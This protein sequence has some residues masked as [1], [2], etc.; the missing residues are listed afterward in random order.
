MVKVTKA[1]LEKIA[2]DAKKYGESLEINELVD[3]LRKLSDKYFNTGKSLVD[4]KSYDTLKDVLKK[5]DPKNVYLKEVGAPIKG[6]KQKVKLPFPMGS[7]DK[8]KPKDSELV[9]S[10]TDKFTGPYVISDKLDG[11]SAQIYKD[12]TGKVTMYSR[13]DGLIGQDISHLLNAVHISAEALK[14]IPK[15]TSIRG[16]LVISKAEFSEIKEK[17]NMENARNTVSGLVNSK[18]VDMDIALIT[19][20]V[21]YTILSPRHKYLDQYKL[22]K[23]WGFE[24]AQYITYKKLE[25]EKLSEYL[26]ERKEKSIYEIDGIVCFDNSKVHTH[27]EGNPDYGFAFK[28]DFD[29]QLVATKIID[30]E[31]NVSK[32]GKLKPVAIVEP[33]RLTGVTVTRVTAINAKYVS[34]NMLGK[35]AIVKITRS[36]DVIPKIIEVV[37][38]AKKAKFPDTPYKW[39]NTGVDI[40]LEDHIKQPSKVMTIKQIAFFFEKIGVQN[41]GEGIVTKLVDNGYDSIEKVLEVLVNEDEHDELYEIDGLGKKMIDKIYENIK[42][43]FEKMELHIFMHASGKFDLGL[44]SKKI[45]EII[46]HIP[47]IMQKKFTDDVLEEKLLEVD[48]IKNILAKNFVDNFDKFKTFY[49]A[50]NKIIDISHIAKNN[51]KDVKKEKEN[52][53]VM[54]GETVVFTGFRDKDIEAFINDNGGKVTGSVSKNT[55]ILVHADNAD[56]TSAKFTKA[57]ELNIKLMSKSGFTDK[58]M[59]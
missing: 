59:K 17:K 34:D 49:K 11:A 33:V 19:H 32:H 18:T 57:K 22:L 43:E 14:K 58:Y 4:D 41:L 54:A 37:K 9:T 21:A 5:R 26:S 1:I 44:G 23:E 50:V 25:V 10:W 20:F 39:N 38:M 7:L 13:G 42:T 46:K 51:N 31:W 16:E 27:E 36:G 24:T 3:L 8:F 53:D 12:A 56:T 29:D 2:N 48:G 6:S 47:D 45:K 52:K 30:I 15:S 35:G 40:L 55:T 28:M